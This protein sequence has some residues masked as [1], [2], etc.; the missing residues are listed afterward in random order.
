MLGALSCGV[1]TEESWALNALG[2]LSFHNALLL[3]A[4]PGLAEALTKASAWEEGRRE[5][6]VC[7]NEYSA[8]ALGAAVAGR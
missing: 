6:R 7:V 2:L 1:P 3:P 4:L 5:D 8:D